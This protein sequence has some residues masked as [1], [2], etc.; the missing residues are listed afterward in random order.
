MATP[1][2][3]PASKVE[4]NTMHVKS[5]IENG[6]VHIDGCEVVRLSAVSRIVRLDTKRDGPEIRLHI[7]DECHEILFN[8]VE[9]RDAVFADLIAAQSCPGP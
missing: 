7:G 4:T 5:I 3:L 8:T 1:E 9:I 2:R 6:W